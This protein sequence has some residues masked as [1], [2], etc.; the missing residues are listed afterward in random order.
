MNV[1]IGNEAAQFLFW[2]YLLR[3]FGVVSLPCVVALACAVLYCLVMFR[4]LS[5]AFVC[6]PML[7]LIFCALLGCLVP[8]CTALAALCFQRWPVLLC[9]EAEFLDEIQTNVLTVFLLVIHNQLYCFVLRFV[10][11]QTH[12]TSYS[13]CKGERKKTWWKTIP[14]SLWFKKSTQKPQV[15]EVSRFCP[16]PHGNCKFMNSACSVLACTVLCF[17]V[18]LSQPVQ[19]CTVLPWAALC[20]P[21]LSIATV[22]CTFPYGVVTTNLKIK[23]EIII[24]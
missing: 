10:F 12:A 18:L 4:V 16:R 17:P 7:F 1:G 9:T 23:N 6:F 19:C 2:E 14:P 20:C 3:I 22:C 24:D 5:C 21:V 11:L 13:F 15:W 8:S